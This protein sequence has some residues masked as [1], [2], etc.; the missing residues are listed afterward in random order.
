[1]C[2]WEWLDIL[3]CGRFVYI[4]LVQ[5]IYPDKKGDP[6]SINFQ[7]QWLASCDEAEKEEIY[8]ASYKTY[9]TELERYF[10][11]AHW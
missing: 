6:T 5:R 2:L 10:L 3:V 1:M 11:F 8:E 4:K 7:E 9:L